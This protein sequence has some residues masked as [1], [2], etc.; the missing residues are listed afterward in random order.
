MPTTI[1]KKPLICSNAPKALTP[2][3]QTVTTKVFYTMLRLGVAFKPYNIK[4]PR[5]NPEQGA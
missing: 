1:N 5:I 4:P 2:K 3:R